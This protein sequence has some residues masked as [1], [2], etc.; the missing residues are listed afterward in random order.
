MCSVTFHQKPKSSS[1]DD[2]TK[3]YNVPTGIINTKGIGW[4]QD[5]DN[6][7][8]NDISRIVTGPNTWIYIY[9]KSGGDPADGKLLIPSDQDVDLNSDFDGDVESFQIFDHDPTAI[10]PKTVNFYQGENFDGR[11]QVFQGAQN[12]PNTKD[13]AWIGDSSD[14]MSDD[15][16]CL[17]TGP[18][19]W[20]M[21]YSEPNY[22]GRS[23][24]IG[25]SQ[26]VNLSYLQ[27]DG[28]S[29]NNSI[30]SF[31]LFDYQPIDSAAIIRN[32][33]ALYPGSQAQTQDNLK[34][35]YFAAQDSEYYVY[36]PLMDITSEKVKFTLK[37]QHKQGEKDDYATVTFSMDYA[38][39][40]VDAIQV[41]YD[42]ADATQIP[43]WMIKL[44]DDEIEAASI[45]AKI[46][47]DAIVD[48]IVD[49]AS[50][51]AAVPL[52]PFI[53]KAIDKSIKVSAKALTF[54]VDHINFVL[55]A[56]FKLQDDGGTMYFAPLVGQSITRLVCAYYQTI[57]GAGPTLKS[58][59]G[60]AFLASICTPSLT[61]GRATWS[62]DGRKNPY[63]EF[64]LAGQNYNSTGNDFRCY[65]PD[66]T[67]I[68]AN[69]G[70]V[71][72]A[73]VVN[74]VN[75]EQDDYLILATAFDN[76][77]NLVAVEGSIDIYAT[78]YPSGYQAPATGALLRDKSGQ[79]WKYL[80]ESNASPVPLNYPDLYTAFK[81]E[82][83]NALN[84]VPTGV[85]LE[86]TN[87]QRALVD[88]AAIVLQGMNA[89]IG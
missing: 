60:N 26:S 79:I 27:V 52:D 53:D 51:G 49:V 5:S 42:L 62:T 47:A 84:Q 78:V 50:E 40:F 39:Q 48:I 57:F 55:K 77:G 37:V 17:K 83:K 24:L 31:Q 54:C 10:A 20:L 85:F 82:M 44:L 36:E 67:T 76:Q 13:K 29:M 89:A 35:R 2:M 45:A 80:N 88:A 28:A 46:M 30:D 15:I 7:M 66:A 59:N 61:N 6:K 34:R 72:S 38:G 21:I 22:G 64:D 43:D 19:T 4:D 87:Q 16:S 69:Y 75:N 18:Q 11:E 73:K 58:F 25:P 56:I 32:F 23:A 86:P 71:C 9:K 33:I 1:K 68:Y 63:I 3:S 14:C 74:L 41:D 8:D 70:T 65:Y 81:T 12:V